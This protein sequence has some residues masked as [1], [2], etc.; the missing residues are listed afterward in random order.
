MKNIIYLTIL[1]FFFFTVACGDG[2]AS[3]ESVAAETTSCSSKS[4][5]KEC[6]KSE[7]K[8]CSKSEKKECSE[9]EKKECSK[10]EKKECCGGEEK[11]CCTSKD[12]EEGH[13]HSH[14]Y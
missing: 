1:S 3:N 13:G 2:D 8:E 6:S 4:E 11:G 5:K 12:R 10:S 7:K 9:S 14:D